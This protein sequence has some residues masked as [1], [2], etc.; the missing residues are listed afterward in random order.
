MVLFDWK[1]AQ[2]F[3]KNSESDGALARE[4]AELRASDCGR[5]NN[6]I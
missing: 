4:V 1:D 6:T 5:Y 2:N 3:E